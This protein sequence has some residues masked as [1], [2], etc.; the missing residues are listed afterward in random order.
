MTPY[1]YCNNNPINLIDPDGKFSTRF[2]AW[3]HKTF[4]GGGGDI[5]KNSYN[6]Y[7]YQTGD[8]TDA[9]PIQAHYGEKGVK[10]DNGSIKGDG[11]R[12][13]G[14][15][16]DAVAGSGDIKGDRGSGS[17][18]AD[19]PGGDVVMLFEFGEL[20]GDAINWLTGNKKTISP[21]TQTSTTTQ[22]TISPADPITTQRVDYKATDPIRGNPSQV[23][24]PNGRDTVVQ[25]KD[26]LKVNELNKRDLKKAQETMKKLN[27]N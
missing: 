20:I 12:V 6:Q 27:E 21:A 15:G 8:G 4:N 24:T 14:Y 11:L 16:G 23:H 7:C 26:L 3:L 13:F 9:S 19:I 10:G 18:Q 22:S 17:I 1:A 2:G 25:R 5:Y